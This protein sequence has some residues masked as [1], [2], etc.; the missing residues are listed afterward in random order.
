MTSLLML[1][2][3]RGDN[4]AWANHST[5]HPLALVL[6]IISG[7]CVISMRR[8]NAILPFLFMAVFVSSAQRVVVASLDFNLLRLLVLCAM[9]RIAMRGEYHK[10]RWSS[11]DLFVL[12]FAISRTAIF[13][14][15]W[16]TSGAFISQA[17][18]TFD[19]VGTYFVARC[20]VRTPSD[21]IKIA[22]GFAWLSIPVFLAF[23]YEFLTHHNPFSMFGGVP[24]MTAIREGRLRCQGA[25]SHPILAG[26]FWASCLPLVISLYWQ[27]GNRKTLALA[28]FFCSM[29]IVM[30]TSSS[31]PVMGVLAVMLGVGLFFVRWWMSWIF[32]LLCLTLFMLHWTMNKPVW[33]LISRITITKGNTGYHRYLLIDNAIRHFGEWWL[34]GTRTTA[35]WFDGALDITNQYILEGVQ[36]GFLTFLLFVMIVAT[37]FIFAAKTWRRAGKRTDLVI[38]AWALWTT[39]FVHSISFISVSYFGQITFL[40]YLHLALVASYAEFMKTAT[41]RQRQLRSAQSAP[42]N[43]SR[44]TSRQHAQPAAHSQ[45]KH[46]GLI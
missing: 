45:P 29:G 11:L 5:I 7:L 33:H 35:N 28:G 42:P 17:G 2:Q 9:F 34:E 10:I 40:W 21:I 46:P 3:I 8:Q 38:L 19:A 1:A 44:H 23:I 32:A 12:L 27:R 41:Q 31:T 39:I 36:G 14:L 22:S 25:F 37:A 6:V 13:T 43:P 30:L 4:V 18:A 15:Q 16:K 26:V 20:L 24:K